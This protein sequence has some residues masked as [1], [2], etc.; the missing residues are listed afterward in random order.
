MVLVTFGVTSLGN[1]GVGGVEDGP[2]PRSLAYES[3]LMTRRRA[4]V[5]VCPRLRVRRR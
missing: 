5:K 2:T 1:P 3:S 4:A